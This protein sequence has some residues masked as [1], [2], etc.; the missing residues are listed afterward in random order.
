MLYG[1]LFILGLCI[2][3]FFNVLVARWGTGEGAVAGRSHCPHCRHTLA[4]YDLIPL[5][6]FV[7]LRGRCRYCHAP[8][9]WRYPLIELVT[10]GLFITFLYQLGLPSTLQ[11]MFFA[12]LALLLLLLFYFDIVHFVLP[13]VI[14]VLIGILSL[15]YLLRTDPSLIPT[16]LLSGF[17]MGLPFAILYVVSRGSWVGFGDVKLTFVL[18]LALGY[19]FGFFAL[20]GGIWSAALVGIAL[21]IVRRA[22]GKTEIP[23]GAFLSAS[24][25]III[26]YYHVFQSFQWY[27]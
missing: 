11:T 9:A 14:L 22:T 3:S 27:F 19:P 26:L 1:L 20:I 15:A 13:D 12:L 4:W 25:I 8:I 16:R 24:A 5:A 6:S 18:G 7:L 2:G 23:F 10:A 21:M 17:L